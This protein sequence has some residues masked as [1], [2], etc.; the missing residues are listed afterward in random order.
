MPTK[1]IPLDERIRAGVTVDDGSGCWTWNGCKNADGY[2]QMMT[3]SRRDG[4]RRTRTVHRVSYELFNGPLEDSLELDHTCNNRACV[5][6]V[7]L[8]QVTHQI[9]TQR[10]DRSHLS[11]PR[12]WRRGIPVTARRTKREWE[13]GL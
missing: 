7:H 12:P 3:G 5:N 13:E 9:N 2:G 1:S 8:R 4:T 6:P 10:S 11:K